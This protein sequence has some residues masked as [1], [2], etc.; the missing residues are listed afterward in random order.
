MP[1]SW[2]GGS[3]LLLLSTGLCFCLRGVVISERLFWGVEA[4]GAWVAVL[5][6]FLDGEEGGFDGGGPDRKRAYSLYLRAEAQGSASLA[7]SP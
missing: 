7:L 2:W 5:R 1:E 6:D 4:E 3:L